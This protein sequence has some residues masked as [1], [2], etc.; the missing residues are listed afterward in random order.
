MRLRTFLPALAVVGLLLSACAMNKPLSDD[1]T[2]AIRSLCGAW[3][4]AFKSNNFKALPALYTD[5]GVLLY[6]GW[7]APK[8]GMSEIKTFWDETWNIINLETSESIEKI[9]GYN[10][11]AFVWSRNTQTWTRE[12][13]EEPVSNRGSVL[14]IVRKQPD[15][16]WLFS[17]DTFIAQ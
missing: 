12:G 9:D 15:G 16:S 6:P 11:L 13:R 1:D 17:V 2:E 3:A 7:G 14:R 10:D 8:Q 4:Q 5:D